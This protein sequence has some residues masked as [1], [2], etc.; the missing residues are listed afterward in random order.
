[1]VS[2]NA[3]IASVTSELSTPSLKEERPITNDKKLNNIIT[4][5]NALRVN[6]FAVTYYA[7]TNV[8]S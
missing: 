2:V 1:M 7:L 6:P 8:K 5:H 4:Y 3:S